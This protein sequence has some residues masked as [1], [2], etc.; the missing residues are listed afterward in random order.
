MYTS[1]RRCEAMRRQNRRKRVEMWFGD[2]L[3]GECDPAAQ[4]RFNV[5]EVVGRL[6]FGRA[7][8]PLFANWNR[9]RI[10]SCP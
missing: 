6:R 5:T 1:R 10:P 2:L 4:I 8:V 7:A 3:S 9:G